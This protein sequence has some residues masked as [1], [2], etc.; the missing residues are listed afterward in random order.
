V[1]DGNL[2]HIM[3]PC[4]AESYEQV[5]QVA[6]AVKQKG[7]KLLRGAAFKPRTSPYDFQGLGVECRRIL[8]QVADDQDLAVVNEIVTHEHV[9]KSLDYVDVIQIGGRNMHKF[10]LL[11][12]AGETN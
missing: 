3:G 1:G 12:A 7:L 8:K 11:K 4:S 9:E 5:A 6:E 2:H 10:E